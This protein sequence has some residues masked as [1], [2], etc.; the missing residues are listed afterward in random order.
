MRHRAH[1]GFCLFCSK[2]RQCTLF[3]CWICHQTIRILLTTCWLER[4]LGG[5]YNWLNTCILPLLVYHCNFACLYNREIHALQLLHSLLHLQLSCNQ[6][7]TWNR[8]TLI[9]SNCIKTQFI[10][11]TIISSINALVDVD[12]ISCLV[13]LG[14]ADITV[15]HWFTT[16]MN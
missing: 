9:R 1:L 2:C 10:F 15:A 3:C 6:K 5:S 7:L 8:I 4:F 12:T 16:S 11:R 14:K 13:I